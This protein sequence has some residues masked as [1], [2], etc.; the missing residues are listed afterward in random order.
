MIWYFPL[1]C[2]HVSHHD[3][4]SYTVLQLFLQLFFFVVIPS[5]N[6]GACSCFIPF[7]YSLAGLVPVSFYLK[8][9]L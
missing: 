2:H 7:V 4:A 3:R 1:L 6:E 5:T 8:F 9:S